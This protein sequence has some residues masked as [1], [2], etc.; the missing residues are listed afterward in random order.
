MSWGRPGDEG[1]TGIAC[2]GLNKCFCVVFIH[3]R[4]CSTMELKATSVLILVCFTI[5]IILTSTEVDAIPSCCLTVT[6][7]IS[8]RMLKSVS[9]HMIQ[10]RSGGCD[11]DALVLFTKNKIICADLKVLEKLEKLKKMKNHKPKRTQARTG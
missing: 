3:T 8:K 9:R 5:I 10:N 4:C 7:K 11:I 2:M 6:K 1:G